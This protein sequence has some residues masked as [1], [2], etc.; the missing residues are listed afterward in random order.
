LGYSDSQKAVKGILLSS[1]LQKTDWYSNPLLPTFPEGTTDQPPPHV[2]PPLSDLG[3]QANPS[4]LLVPS[5]HGDGIILANLQAMSR[6]AETSDFNDPLEALREEDMNEDGLG[7]VDEDVFKNLPLI[8]D[9]DMS[10]D[11]TKR[12]RQA[13]GSDPSSLDLFMIWFPS[14]CCHFTVLALDVVGLL[15]LWLWLDFSLNFPLLYLVIT[16]SS[17]GLFVMMFA[18]CFLWLPH[19]DDVLGGSRY[20][21][22]CD[23]LCSYVGV[24]LVT[25]DLSITIMILTFLF[26]PL[27]RFLCSLLLYLLGGGCW[28]LS[29]NLVL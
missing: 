10:F 4:S 26:Y 3:K 21:M 1:G 23:Q 27:L 14:W 5:F 17:E 22:A 28:T 29:L 8:E 18:D 20:C 19:C 11:S 15:L 25:I 6:L 24:N 13:V 16:L 2:H 9:V 12:K 7:Q